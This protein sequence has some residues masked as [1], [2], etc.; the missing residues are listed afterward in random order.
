VLGV[1]LG[2][3]WCQRFRCS[4]GVVVRHSLTIGYVLVRDY[5]EPGSR[6]FY[7]DNNR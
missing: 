6:D 5:A 1:R 7:D 3:G 4:G 2:D